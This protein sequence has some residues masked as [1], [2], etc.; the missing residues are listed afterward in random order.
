MAAFDKQFPTTWPY[1]VLKTIH[2]LC[3]L[4]ALITIFFVE[5]KY[6][7]FDFVLFVLW[8]T[9]IYS[10]ITWLC[11]LFGVQRGNLQ[12]GSSYYF[13][14]P[15]ALTDFFFC[16]V[17]AF[18]LA[19]SALISVVSFFYSF[20]YGFATILV[21]LIETVLISISTVSY[22][23]YALLIYRACPNG[24]LRN[25]LTMYI[26]GKELMNIDVDVGRPPI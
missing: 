15:F 4:A 20:K 10:C 24:N 17:G 22:S 19:V 6:G 26:D 21:Y 16:S 8:N 3:P 5:T 14:I 12:V 25:L 11:Y 1:G 13:F 7:S 9:F 23:Y 18:C 2:W